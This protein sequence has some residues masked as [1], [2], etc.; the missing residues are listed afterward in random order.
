MNDMTKKKYNVVIMLGDIQGYYPSEQIKGFYEAADKYDANV[1]L[2]VG[3]QIPNNVNGVIINE[4]DKAYKYQFNTIYDY[5]NLMHPDAI[6]VTYGSLKIF[7]SIENGK[8]F[9]GKFSSVPLIMMEDI[10]EDDNISYLITDSY[11]GMYQCVEHLVKV[12]GYKRITFLGAP[13]GNLDGEERLRAYKDVMN[14][15]GLTVTDSMIGRGDYSEF[16]DYEV[17]KLID[18]NK[19][20]EAIVCANDGMAKSCYRVCSKR[21]FE[22]GKQIAITGYDNTSYSKEMIPNLT[23]VSH[24]IKQ[25]SIRA[26][27]MAMDICKGK[28]PYHINVKAKFLPRGSCG[29]QFDHSAMKTTENTLSTADIE[30]NIRD[31]IWFIPSII[32]DIQFV[33]DYEDISMI[34]EYV[35]H[36]ISRMGVKSAYLLDFGKTVQRE[37]KDITIPEEM[38]LKAYYE[39]GK[40]VSYNESVPFENVFNS[41]ENKRLAAFMIFYGNVQYGVIM[42]EVEP[43]NII[44]WQICSLQLG[45]LMHFEELNIEKYKANKELEEKN[46]VLNFISQKDE[47]TGILNRHGFMER[48]ISYIDNNIGKKAQILFADLDHLKQINDGFGH[49]DGDYAILSAAEILQKSLPNDIILAR[50]GGDE[51]VALICDSNITD[52]ELKTAIKANCDFFNT[53]S[54]KQYYIEMS[55]GIY[56]FVCDAGIE[57][58]ELLKKSDKLLYEAKKNRR[59]NVLK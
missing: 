14:K 37:E 8:E 22:I 38:R 41:N 27:D 28:K 49:P 55:V 25:M 48:V 43:Q 13:V 15:Y 44:Y 12:H 59:D 39:K 45:T 1:I 42:L 4:F 19:D 24:D 17:E 56:E 52:T 32:R 31:K 47:L 6:I 54:S 30:M 23:T 18:R 9:L 46:R 58:S 29:C 35:L 40:V 16:V 34:L 36:R 7:K 20:L 10:P 51:F 50:I 26:F 5:A 2:L 57:I 11:N 53:I 21:G 3:Q 33:N